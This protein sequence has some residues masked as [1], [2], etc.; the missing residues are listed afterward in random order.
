MDW[1]TREGGMTISLKSIVRFE[2]DDGWL[3]ED[4]SVYVLKQMIQKVD[5]RLRIMWW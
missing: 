2:I 5:V 4:C 1:S 3:A